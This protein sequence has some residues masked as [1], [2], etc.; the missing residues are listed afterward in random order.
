MSDA[1]PTPKQSLANIVLQRFPWLAGVVAV[2]GAKGKGL[3]IRTASGLLHLA[4]GPD[5]PA[6]HRVGDL[7]DGGKLTVAG[8][9]LG[10]EGADGSTK[11][12]ITAVANT[13]TGAV[14]F[15]LVPN[16]GDLGALVTKA[17]KGSERVTCG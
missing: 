3:A 14:T 9:A 11:W 5:D 17:T 10:Y 12:S 2:A 8:L 16:A 4:G 1:V 15:S 6:V 13:S 7:G